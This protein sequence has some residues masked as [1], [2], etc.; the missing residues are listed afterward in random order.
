[1]KRRQ[2][3]CNRVHPPLSQDAQIAHSYL[4]LLQIHDRLKIPIA[5]ALAPG[6]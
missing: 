6:G 2:D 3:T 1:M 4:V 5:L